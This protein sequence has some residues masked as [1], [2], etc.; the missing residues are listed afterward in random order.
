M[1]LEPRDPTEVDYS[2]SLNNRSPLTQRV[3]KSL[4]PNASEETVTR[5]EDQVAKAGS[6]NDAMNQFR[7]SVVRQETSEFYKLSNLTP[8]GKAS[9]SYKD[10]H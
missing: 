10:S 5:D 3:L 1:L 2:T 7:L 9:Q 8:D 6:R 4:I